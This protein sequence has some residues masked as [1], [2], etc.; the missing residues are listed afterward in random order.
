MAIH[1]GQTWQHI[2][3]RYG[4][5]ILQIWQHI[6]DRYGKTYWT[7]MATI[8]DRYGNNIGQIWQHVTGSP[9]SDQPPQKNNLLKDHIVVDFTAKQVS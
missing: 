6:L 1:I 3:D 7:D 8:L 2:L 5:N 9:G 4:N